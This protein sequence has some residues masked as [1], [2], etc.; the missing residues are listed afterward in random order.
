MLLHHLKQATASLASKAFHP[1]TTANYARQAQPYIR[2]CDHYQFPF[3]L[4]SVATMCFYVTHLSTA[5][6]STRSIRNYIS[7]VR[8]LHNQLGAAPEA[9]D[10]FPVQC[11]LRIE[12]LTM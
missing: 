8:F 1:G 5:F 7:G 6:S 9:V 12:D 11:L 10:S 2:L 3:I 4:P